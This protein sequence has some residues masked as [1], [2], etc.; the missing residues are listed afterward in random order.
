L[1][2]NLLS[3]SD[4]VLDLTAGSCISLLTAFATVWNNSGVGGLLWAGCD[5]GRKSL[6]AF[7]VVSDTINTEV[8][9]DGT[10]LDAFL[11]RMC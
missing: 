9:E 11:R 3:Q 8:A 1:E 6:D 5:I 2:N 4:L 10:A 7:E